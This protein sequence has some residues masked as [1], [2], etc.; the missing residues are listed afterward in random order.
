MEKFQNTIESTD[1]V[2]RPAL[3]FDELPKPQRNLFENFIANVFRILNN[4]LQQIED[5]EL[6]AIQNTITQD[7]K[8]KYIKQLN[9]E[10]E[11]FFMRWQHGRVG[12]GSFIKQKINKIPELCQKYNIKLNNI[13]GNEIKTSKDETLLQAST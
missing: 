11:L 13:N 8:E 12:R 9:E 5:L 1:S 6:L 4:K 2:E 10:E 7:E 3:K